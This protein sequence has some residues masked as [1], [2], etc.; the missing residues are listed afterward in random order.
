MA[1]LNNQDGATCYITL[2]YFY[3][4]LKQ[5]PM[6]RWFT[7][8][9]MLIYHNYL[10]L[11]EGKS[12]ACD[13]R[14]LCGQALHGPQGCPNSTATS[15]EFLPQPGLHRGTRVISHWAVDHWVLAIGAND[16]TGGWPLLDEYPPDMVTW[17]RKISGVPGLKL[18]DHTNWL[19]VWNRL[20]YH[21]PFSWE[22]HHPNWLSYLSEGLKPSTSQ[23]MSG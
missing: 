12:K 5:W 14:Y 16:I 7:Q 22:C 21:F 6:Y 11:P 13:W 4:A 9:K 10:T 3:V 1:M 23:E 8:S 17:L 18:L 19:V 15:W 2:W 20:D